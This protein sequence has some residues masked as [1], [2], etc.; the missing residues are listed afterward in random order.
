MNE[1]CG[2]LIRPLVTML[3]TGKEKTTSVSH[4]GIAVADLEKAMARYALIWG[5]D[6]DSVHDVP[7]QKVRVAF[8]ST[9]ETSTVVPAARVE[10]LAATSPDSPIARFIERRGEGLHH[11]CLFVDDIEARMAELKKAGVKLIDETPR[12][13]AEGSRIAFVHP[14]DAGSVLIELEERE[15]Q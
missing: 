13:G 15:S 4:I 6:A 12:R 11:I 10:L 7:D 1:Y 5:A 9:S 14:A 2:P 8:F 3:K